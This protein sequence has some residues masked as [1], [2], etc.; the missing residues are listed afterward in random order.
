MKRISTLILGLLLILVFTLPARAGSLTT[1]KFIYKPSL[2]ARGDT[3]KQTFDAGDGS[4]RRP[5]GQGDL[6]RRPGYRSR[7]G[8]AGRI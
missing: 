2:G 1:N 7:P 4:H 6:G 3:E 5:P 8:D